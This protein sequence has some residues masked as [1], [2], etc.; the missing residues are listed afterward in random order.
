MHPGDS[1]MWL[2]VEGRVVDG[3]LAV[4]TKFQQS[5]VILVHSANT[6]VPNA[7]WP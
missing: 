5:L 1:M 6:E 3:E 2:C 7:V 4:G